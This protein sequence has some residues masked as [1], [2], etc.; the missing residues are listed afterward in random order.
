MKKILEVLSYILCGFAAIVG[1]LAGGI[2]L[3]VAS[4]FNKVLG[5]EA[6]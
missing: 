6:I 3:V 5:S 4:L 1:L 2:V